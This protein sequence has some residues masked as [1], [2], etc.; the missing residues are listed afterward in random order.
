MS[1]T[2]PALIVFE[3]KLLSGSYDKITL[4]HTILPL[5]VCLIRLLLEN[6]MHIFHTDTSVNMSSL[7]A[8]RKVLQNSVPDQ[9]KKV[10]AYT[11]SLK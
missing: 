6:I 9:F 5:V 3:W 10:S 4:F 11:I 8:F 2:G 1:R 7:P